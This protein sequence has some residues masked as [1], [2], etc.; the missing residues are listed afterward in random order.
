MARS[1]IVQRRAFPF[2]LAT[3]ALGVSLLPACSGD[4]QVSVP[5]AGD[6]AQPTF[7]SQPEDLADSPQLEALIERD[8]AGLDATSESAR[9]DL[10]P[11]ALAALQALDDA[12]KVVSR[13]SIY[14]DSVY[15]T[16][17]DGGRTGRSVTA[18]YRSPD[19]FYISDPSYDDSPTFPIGLVQPEVAQRLIDAIE[20]RFPQ[21]RVTSLDLEPPLSY[22]FGLVWYVDV[23]DA[24]GSLATVFA[25][26]DGSIVAV[27]MS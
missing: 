13:L 17:L 26:L 18:V 11:E 15:F 2:G 5:T 24:R 7:R 23:E 19:D 21:A 8:T 25:D 6:I 4:R 12:P 3:L 20:Q 16:F 10:L 22:D 14:N 27:D 1:R 9:G